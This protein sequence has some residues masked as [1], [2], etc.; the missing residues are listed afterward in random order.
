[1][2]LRSGAYHRFSLDSEHE[3]C[4]SAAFCIVFSIRSYSER[5]NKKLK[6][7]E[8]IYALKYFLCNANKFLKIIIVSLSIKQHPFMLS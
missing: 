7:V 4:E 1:M 8:K 3:M 2:I 6:I 5:Y